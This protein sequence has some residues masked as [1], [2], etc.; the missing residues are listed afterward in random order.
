MKVLLTGGCGYIGSH[1]C[2]ELL[3]EEHE[4]VIID[5]LSNSN[6]NN[7]DRMMSHF[8]VHI[9][10][11]VHDLQNFDQTDRVFRD[12]N[13]DVVIHLAG[14]KSVRESCA[15]PVKYYSNNVD[16]TLILLQVMEKH[17]CNKL[18]FSSSATVYQHSDK[19]LVEESPCRPINPYGKSKLMIE[20]ILQDHFRA[21]K[22]NWCITNLRYFNPIGAHPSGLIGEN[23]KGTPENL[24]PFILKV[25]DGT[26]GH[27][28]IFGDDYNTHDG[29]CIRD[30]IHIC[31][32][33]KGHLKAMKHLF[34]RNKQFNIFNLGTGR[35]YSVLEIV[36]AFEKLGCRVP[37]KINDRRPGDNAIVFADASFAQEELKWK[38]KYHINDMCQHAWSWW[39]KNIN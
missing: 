25:I 19:A 26:F 13:I 8:N 12:N 30:Y 9:P 38:P 16:S 24:V 3:K 35:G 6:L 22:L 33:A 4:V 7:M 10:L 17:Q 23:P 39:S 32:L 21:S 37:Y 18:I 15:L 11:Y 31:D 34:S 36:K 1:I 29:T 5:N 20:M 28:N 2:W 27:L 14:L